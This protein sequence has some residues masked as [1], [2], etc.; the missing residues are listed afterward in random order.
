MRKNTRCTGFEI[1]LCALT[2]PITIT[3]TIQQLQQEYLSLMYNWE[4][5]PSSLLV[6]KIVA[7]P[8]EMLANVA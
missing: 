4:T 3:L 6:A 2:T 8:L 5:I 1:N 7:K